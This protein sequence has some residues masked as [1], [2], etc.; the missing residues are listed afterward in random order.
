[1]AQLSLPIQIETHERLLGWPIIRS[2]RHP[3]V[4]AMVRVLGGPFAG[5]DYVYLLHFGRK[6]Y[7]T[8]HY[9]GSTTDPER[10]F[11]EHRRMYPL[12]RLDDWFFDRGLYDAGIPQP[13]LDALAPE[14][15]KS[16]RR[17]ATFRKT[18]ARRLD[19][20]TCTV[21]ELV[22]LKHARRDNG[23]PLLMAVNRAGIPWQVADLWQANRQ[24]EYKLKRRKQSSLFCRVC[25]GDDRPF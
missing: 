10:R 21:Y 22:I 11:H 9:L 7:H 18:L 15:G 13:A 3:R 2:Y 1:M 23:V 24:L 19:E 4:P 20:H 14:R 12:F 8:Q 6:Y 25:Q 5:D 17:Y 16:F